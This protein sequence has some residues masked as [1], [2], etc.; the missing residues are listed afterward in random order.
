MHIR[1][2]FKRNLDCSE[3]NEQR[4]GININRFTTESPYLL[5]GLIRCS[6]CNFNF[7]G[8]S[9]LFG[10][11]GNRKKEYVYVDSGY[12]RKG[13]SVCASKKINKKGLETFILNLIRERFLNANFQEKIRKQLI[14]NSSSLIPTSGKEKRVSKTIE[15][16]RAENDFIISISGK[17]NAS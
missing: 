2:S 5:S 11:P 10:R 4:N 17:R 7:T 13:P 15:R 16:M 9:M 12:E 1:H 8:R 6:H 3:F 14:K